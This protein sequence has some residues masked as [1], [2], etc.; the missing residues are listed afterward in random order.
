M[1]FL[2]PT[3][4]YNPNNP[5]LGKSVD[6]SLNIKSEEYH[7]KKPSSLP[8]MLIGETRTT[9]SSV[10]D[11][12]DDPLSILRQQAWSRIQNHI[13]KE[14][15]L[16]AVMCLLVFVFLICYLPFWTVFLCLVS[17]VINIGGIPQTSTFNING[18]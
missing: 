7:I 14:K 1:D 11:F 2:A 8:L 18:I 16:A 17:T 10:S 13:T 9:N 5:G 6:T 15:R 3:P 4:L 12:F